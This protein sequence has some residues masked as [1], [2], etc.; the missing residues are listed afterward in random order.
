MSHTGD[1]DVLKEIPGYKAI[2]KSVIKSQ[3][4]LLIEQLSDQTGEESI[5]LTASI[6]DGTLSHLGSNMGKGFFEGHEEIKSQFLGYCLKSH[7]RGSD[8]KR[9]R[10]LFQRDLDERQQDSYQQEPSTTKRQKSQL[11]DSRL[12][13]TFNDQISHYLS[14]A[15]PESIQIYPH[16]T[17]FHPPARQVL[18]STVAHSTCDSN[19]N[20][21]IGTDADHV[22][23]EPDIEGQV[24]FSSV[25]EDIR[26]SST[27]Q[28]AKRRDTQLSF[29][30]SS[31]VHQPDFAQT[32]SAATAVG[33]KIEPSCESESE[34]EI[35]GIEL[36]EPSGYQGDSGQG[37]SIDMEYQKFEQEILSGNQNSKC[38]LKLG[39]APDR[40]G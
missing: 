21:T 9:P 26:V 1:F 3:I 28:T 2:L 20:D 33:V 40:K 4:Q 18:A 7:Q 35:T 31:G 19:S 15:A 6:N 13:S 23:R 39:N 24:S 38:K 11:S 29:T 22:K 8:R 27:H 16:V 5:I 17:Q 32:D 25:A 36:S 10:K 34:L 37:V 14:T 12:V 30:G